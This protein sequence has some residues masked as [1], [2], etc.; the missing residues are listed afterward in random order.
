MSQ[1]NTELTAALLNN[2]SI[3]EFFRSHL[4]AASDDLLKTELTAFLGYEKNSTT[5]Y[6][7]GNSHNGY[8]ERDLD[9]K[10]GK[11][12]V[13]IPRDRNK[14][15]D[16]KLISGYARRTHDLETTIITLYRKGITTREI[17]GLVEKL[18]G[19]YYSPATVSNISKAVKSQVEE[20]HNRRLSDKY[21][22]IFMDATY[23]NVR[24]DSVAKEPLHVLSGITPD[25]TREVLDYALYPTESA[26]NYE[27]MMASIKGRGVEQVLMFASDGLKGMRDAVKR[28]FPDANHQQ[29]LGPSLPDGCQAY[30]SKD[31]KEILGDLKAVYRAGSEPAAAGALEG[32]LEKHG[33]QYPKLKGIFDRY[34]GSLFYV[35]S[36][37]RSDLEEHLHYE[38]Y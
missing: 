6:N 32:F 37:S 4:K 18:Y 29:C 24:R 7:T 31:R 5:G 33:K 26:A 22:V 9:T 35:L 30:P 20:F 12:H 2:E 38:H 8:Y 28:Q 14:A 23:L 10:Y 27:E 19:H 11:L 15:F 13:S 17:A 1:V 21:V 36:F 25:G 3:D 34:N 16:Q